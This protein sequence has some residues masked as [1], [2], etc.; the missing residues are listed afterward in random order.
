M[1]NSTVRMQVLSTDWKWS[2]PKAEPDEPG[3]LGR[4]TG[5][6]FLRRVGG[7]SN[8]SFIS[9][10]DLPTDHF[11]YWVLPSRVFSTKRIELSAARPG[12]QSFDPPSTGI[13]A[14][15]IQRA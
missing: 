8:K 9:R 14:P 11:D 5:T 6:F 1:F 15:V 12:A 2:L 13:L 10:L 7:Y 3:T 4:D